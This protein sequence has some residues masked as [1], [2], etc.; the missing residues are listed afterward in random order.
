MVRHS[1]KVSKIAIHLEAAHLKLLGYPF[2]SKFAIFFYQ[3]P[4]PHSWRMF[5]LPLFRS[6]WGVVCEITKRAG[7][8]NATTVVRFIEGGNNLRGLGRMQAFVEISQ[9]RRQLLVTIFHLYQLF[10][11]AILDDRKI[12]LPAI[13]V[14]DIAKLAA[15][16]AVIFKIVQKFEKGGGDE[17]FEPRSLCSGTS[18]LSKK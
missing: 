1:V 17:V 9:C 15:M 11:H 8:P 4:S 7:D 13:L 12:D 5:S 14:A 10:Q 16:T 3:P 6:P 18:S 2:I